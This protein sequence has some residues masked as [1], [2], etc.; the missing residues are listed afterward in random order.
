MIGEGTDKSI[1]A[2]MEERIAR[3]D[4]ENGIKRSRILELNGLVWNLGE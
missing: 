2:K 4:T 3:K 1:S